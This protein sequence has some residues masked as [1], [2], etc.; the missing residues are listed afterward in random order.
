[1]FVAFVKGLGWVKFFEVFE[2]DASVNRLFFTHDIT[3]ATQ[4][5]TKKDMDVAINGD[6]QFEGFEMRKV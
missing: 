5:S 3:E 1:M 6:F 4:W 2:I